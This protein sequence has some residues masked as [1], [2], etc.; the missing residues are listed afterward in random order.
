MSRREKG[1]RSTSDPPQAPRFH[2]PHFTDVLENAKKT[3]HNDRNQVLLCPWI[4]GVWLELGQT[5][6]LVHVMPPFVQL[7]KAK[8]TPNPCQIQNEQGKVVENDKDFQCIDM[9][10]GQLMQ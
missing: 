10:P 8:G 7:V 1:C 3:V 4:D 6:F 9:L 2:R 5:C